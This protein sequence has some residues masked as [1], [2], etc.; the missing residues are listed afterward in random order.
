[1]KIRKNIYH[2]SIRYKYLFVVV[3]GGTT[4]YLAPPKTLDPDASLET[5]DLNEDDSGLEKFLS[6]DLLYDISPLPKDDDDNLTPTKL[7][8]REGSR[9]T[10]H[11]DTNSLNES[12]LNDRSIP[13]SLQMYSS[14]DED[15]EIDGHDYSKSSNNTENVQA[16]LESNVVSRSE[17]IYYTPDDTLE[18]L[19]DLALN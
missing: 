9:E 12:A 14:S 2:Y 11:N 13:I 6:E 5:V 7:Y 4:R 10:L 18:R 3:T 16:Q 15:K 19:S 17:S 1:M 8:M